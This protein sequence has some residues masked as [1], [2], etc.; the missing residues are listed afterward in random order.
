[1]R[2]PALCLAEAHRGDLAY[3][4]DLLIVHPSRGY[5][6][7]LEVDVAVG[8]VVSERHVAKIRVFD[9]KTKRTLGLER[10]VSK[11]IN[12]VNPRGCLSLNSLTLAKSRAGDLCVVGEEDLLVLA[13]AVTGAESILYGQPDV[14]AVL[15]KPDL[16]KAIK[17]LKILKPAVVQVRL[18]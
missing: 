6:A 3:P 7:G 15:M 13:F 18:S 12:V 4:Q 11:C 16:N 5:L 8:D 2:I 10:R 17:V 14:G 1:M 9:Y